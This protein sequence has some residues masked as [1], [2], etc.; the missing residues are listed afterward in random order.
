MFKTPTLRNV[1]TR[2]VFFHNG[3]IKSLKDAIRFYNTRDTDPARW[4][5]TVNGVLQIFDDLPTEFRS[6]IDK[7]VPLDQRAPGSTPAM[8]DQDM[9][10]L[11]AFLKTLTDNYKAR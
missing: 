3:A 8:T 2:K 6:N 9:D 5:P 1:A 4:Y 10:D 11:E 7:Q